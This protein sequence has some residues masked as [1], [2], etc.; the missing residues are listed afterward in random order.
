METTKFQKI[1]GTVVCVLDTTVIILATPSKGQEIKDFSAF[2]KGSK[3]EEVGDNELCR[4]WSH[5]TLRENRRIF[6]KPLLGEE[7]QKRGHFLVSHGKKKRWE[8][9]TTNEC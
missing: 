9:P 8:V 1:N 4:L 7:L 2:P 3:I 6:T 5:G